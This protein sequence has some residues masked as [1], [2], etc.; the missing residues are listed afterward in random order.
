MPESKTRKAAA[1]KKKNSDRAQ[2][3][4]K[5][6]ETKRTVAAPGSRQWVPPTFITVGLLGV[7]WL[8]VYYITA[9][10]GV[11]IP[12]MTDLGAWNV[13][14]G[15]GGMAAAFAIATLWK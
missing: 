1:E 8:V 12:V 6:D 10:V 14:I 2:L 13:L 9:S 7:L 15:M 5:R 3:A 11:T 4:Q